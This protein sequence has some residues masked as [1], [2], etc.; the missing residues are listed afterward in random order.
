MNKRIRNKKHKK[1]YKTVDSNGIVLLVLFGMAL[2]A[3]IKDMKINQKDIKN[4]AI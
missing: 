3:A 1:R 2:H 4:A